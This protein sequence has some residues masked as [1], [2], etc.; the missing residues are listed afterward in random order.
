MS[1]ENNEVKRPDSYDA[2]FPGRFLKAGL[3]EGKTPTLTI[4]DV[5]IE[6]LPTDKGEMQT[7]GILSFEQTE[8]QLSLNKTNGTCLKAMFGTKPVEWIGK[9]VTFC[10]EK[11]RFGKDTV[12]AIR[13]KGSP[14]LVE[15]ID[16]VIKMPKKKDKIRRLTKTVKAAPKAESAAVEQ[17]V[18]DT[19]GAA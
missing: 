2:M 11:D 8:M 4:S 15:D 14:D 13:I 6:K 16:V 12:D 1:E 18:S 3:F 5:V 10:S 17:P 19:N 9:R 7:K